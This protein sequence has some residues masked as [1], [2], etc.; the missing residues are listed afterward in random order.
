[1]ADVHQGAT[2][3][4]IAEVSA[5]C[6]GVWVGGAA[7]RL[8]SQGFCRGNAAGRDDGGGDVVVGVRR[9]KQFQEKLLRRFSFC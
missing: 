1:M 4:C 8:P 6:G 7:S 3:E 9:I 5:V 2:A